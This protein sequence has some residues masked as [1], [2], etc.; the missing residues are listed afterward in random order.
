MPLRVSSTIQL[1][2]AI[3]LY[4]IFEIEI[5]LADP[6]TRKAIV[7][8]PAPQPAKKPAKK[9]TTRKKTETS[10]IDPESATEAPKPRKLRAKKNQVT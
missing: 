8:E 7:V 2:Y 1:V 4:L 6:R 10:V 5:L 3:A 9:R